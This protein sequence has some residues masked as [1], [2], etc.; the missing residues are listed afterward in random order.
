MVFCPAKPEDAEKISALI[1]SFRSELTL[2]SIGIG[3][4]K[5]LASVSVESERSYI[6]SDRYDY[7]IAEEGGD[8]AGFIAI[9]DQTHVFHM[10]VARHHQR[11]GLAKE[12]WRRS[13][14]ERAHSSG[15]GEAF[16][17]NSSL[18]AEPVYKRFGF[19]RVSD[20]IQEAGIEFVPIRRKRQAS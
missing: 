18:I 8:L 19:E 17:V 9:R 6:E 2:E 11:C 15:S 16:T 12:L 3:A 7:L 1:L 10:F 5:F 14:E 13:R 20:P 4:E